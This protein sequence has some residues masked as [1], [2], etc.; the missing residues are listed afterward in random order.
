MGRPIESLE[1]TDEQRRE[2]ERIVNAPTS[3]QRL[4]GRARIVLMRAEGRRQDATAADEGESRP[5]VIRWER[6]F[7]SLGLAGLEEA[8]GRGPKS[9]IPE[10]KR[11]KLIIQ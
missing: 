2:L 7:S 4:V 9:S 5:A 10:A 1:I 8:P 11:E 3:P 6:R